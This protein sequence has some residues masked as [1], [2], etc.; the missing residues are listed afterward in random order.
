MCVAD[1]QDLLLRRVSHAS[2]EVFLYPVPG[3]RAQ[4]AELS[5]AMAVR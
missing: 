3:T 2:G 5:A 4:P 1:E